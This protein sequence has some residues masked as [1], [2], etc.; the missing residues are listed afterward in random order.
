MTND[1]QPWWS[2]IDACRVMGVNYTQRIVN[3]LGQGDVCAAYLIED[4]IETR[5]LGVNEAGLRDLIFGYGLSDHCSFSELSE[6]V[7]RVFPCT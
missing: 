1:N 5:E 4:R 7:K 6:S 2:L 3:H